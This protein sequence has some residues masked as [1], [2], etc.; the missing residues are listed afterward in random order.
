MVSKKIL[1]VIFL[2]AF[3]IVNTGQASEYYTYEQSTFTIS[4]PKTWHKIP[5][6]YLDAFAEQIRMQFRNNSSVNPDWAIYDCGF[7]KNFTD[8]GITPPAVIIKT[9]YN[10]KLARTLKHDLDTMSEEKFSLTY[11]QAGKI[12]S[13]KISQIIDSSVKNILFDKRKQMLRFSLDSSDGVNHVKNLTSIYISKDTIYHIMCTT[14]ANIYS[15]DEKTFMHMSNSFQVTQRQQSHPSQDTNVT[16]NVESKEAQEKLQINEPV[17]GL[18]QGQFRD[19]IPEDKQFTTEMVGVWKEFYEEEGL[20][21]EC[22]IIYYPDHTYEQHTTYLTDYDAP[23]RS[24]GIWMVRGGYVYYKDGDGISSIRILS[25]DKQKASYKW[26]NGV[27]CKGFR[28]DLHNEGLFKRKDYP[29]FDA[30]RNMDIYKEQSTSMTNAFGLMIKDVIEN[31]NVF[32]SS[33]AINILQD[34]IN[35][36]E[37]NAKVIR[38]SVKDN[39]SRHYKQIYLVTYTIVRGSNQNEYMYEYN[40]KTNAIQKMVHMHNED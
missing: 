9:D 34:W 13:S 23:W 16:T 33:H 29:G 20:E 12:L 26:D 30:D 39:S 40:L 10:P 31:Y 25:I 32:D 18:S 15:Q 19:P 38:L 27:I 37:D 28:I 21:I 4:V 11:Q 1:P 35:I 7:Q 14:L 8:Y 2:L 36:L 24:T 17:T 5:Q 3:G 22:L 6:Q